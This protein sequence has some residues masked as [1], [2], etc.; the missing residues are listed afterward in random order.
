[1]ALHHYKNRHRD[2]G[3]TAYEIGDDY[4]KVEFAGGPLYMY[5]HEIPGAGHVERMKKLALQGQGLSTYISRNIRE[6]YAER[7]R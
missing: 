4:I 6:N 2:S 1:M 3:V 7:L 5:T